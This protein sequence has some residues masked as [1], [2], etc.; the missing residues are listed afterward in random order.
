LFR[1][2]HDATYPHF[3]KLHTAAEDLAH[4]QKVLQSNRTI[5]IEKDGEI[6]GFCACTPG[7]VNYLYVLPR[8]QG[9]GLG[10][11]LL[12]AAKSD[13]AALQLWT[14]QENL[15]AR[16]FYE[17]HGFRAVEETGGAGNEEKQPDVRYVWERKFT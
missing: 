15:K 17:R 9:S 3:P 16:K 11:R 10:S 6:A 12:D 5:V 7:W 14:F 1:A 4:F 8:Y 2:T 13:T